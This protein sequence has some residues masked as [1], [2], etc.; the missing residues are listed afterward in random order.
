MIFAFSNESLERAAALL[1]TGE[2]VGMPT[3]TVYGLAADATSKHAV[4]QVYLLKGRPSANPLIVHVSS[5]AQIGAAADLSAS[6]SASARL[7]RLQSLFPGPLSVVLPKHRQ[8][9]DRVCAGGSS[10]AVRVPAHPIARALIDAAGK[11]LAAPSANLS[12]RLSPTTAEHVASAFGD[13]LKLILDGGPSIV[14]LESTVISLI[15]DRPVILRPGAIGIELLSDLLGEAVQDGAIVS[16]EGDAP[17]LSP[18][19]LPK[20]YA[21]QTPVLFSHQLDSSI[22]TEQSALLTFTPCSAEYAARFATY[23]C[24][25]APLERAAT[26]LFAALHQLDR[27][28]L[29]AIVIEPCPET[30]IGIAIMD[31]LRRAAA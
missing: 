12:N 3:E 16:Q 14:G 30:G 28:N 31:R 25:D 29:D 6:S 19:L 21:P 8:I 22:R 17:L 2:V 13:R 23:H 11:P 5:F 26:Q 10:V 18:G 20:H 24:L 27:L 1:R 15:G 9:A 4:E 7:E